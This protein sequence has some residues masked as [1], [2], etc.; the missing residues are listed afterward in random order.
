MIATLGHEA[1]HVY[2]F[3]K[4]NAT[5]A[6]IWDYAL[7]IQ[8]AIIT[9]DEDFVIRSNMAKHGPGVVWVRTGNLG[10]QAQIEWFRPLLSEIAEKIQSGERLIELT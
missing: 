9:K 1:E 8:A 5:D 2:D 4:Q 7:S 3:A 10:R 6:E